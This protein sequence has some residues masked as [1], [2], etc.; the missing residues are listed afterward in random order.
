MEG[1]HK[2]L[3]EANDCIVQRDELKDLLN[4]MRNASGVEAAENPKRYEAGSNTTLKI[5]EQALLQTE[6]AH[7]AIQALRIIS[8]LTSI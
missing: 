6:A 4:Q 1:E 2:V 8:T 3:V 5:A 7:E